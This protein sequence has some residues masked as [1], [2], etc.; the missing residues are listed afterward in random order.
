MSIGVG[1]YLF[2]DKKTSTVPTALDPREIKDQ[3][4]EELY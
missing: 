1:K 4:L 3:S 2:K